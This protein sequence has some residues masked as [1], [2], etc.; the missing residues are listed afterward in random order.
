MDFIEK[1]NPVSY[2]LR[3]ILRRE[4]FSIIPIKK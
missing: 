4:L 2:R 3:I 1:S